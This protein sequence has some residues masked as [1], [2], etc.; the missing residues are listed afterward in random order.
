MCDIRVSLTETS[1]L[2][3]SS[4]TSGL[5]V[6]VVSYSCTLDGLLLSYYRLYFSSLSDA[7]DINIFVQYL[8]FFKEKKALVS[9]GLKRLLRKNTL[10]MCL[11]C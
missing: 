7:V 6:H 3:F 10:Y 4:L 2:E 1:K 5:I 8:F 11:E 9:L